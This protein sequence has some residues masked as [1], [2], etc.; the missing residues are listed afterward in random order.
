MLI[1]RNRI[2]T[3]GHYTRAG[4]AI[5]ALFVTPIKDNAMIRRLA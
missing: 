2:Q 3:G 5:E 4:K 1:T